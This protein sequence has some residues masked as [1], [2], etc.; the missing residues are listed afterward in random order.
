MDLRPDRAA[1]PGT[2][3]V[4]AVIRVRAVPWPHGPAEQ[5]AAG[6]AAAAEALAAAGSTERT[7]PRGPGGRPRF[8]PGF[9]GSISHTGRLAVAVV[10]PGAEAVGIDV[11]D[12]VVTA[13]TARF[14]L[15]ERERRT[16]LA[17]AGPYPPRELF[18]AKEAAFKALSGTGDTPDGLPFW[19]IGLN[20]S[21]GRLTARYGGR[22]V[23]VWTRSRTDHSL[24]LAI[25]RR[26][27]HLALIGDGKP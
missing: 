3:A 19:R 2:A 21:G 8:P 13:R 23:P 12:A 16:L 9:P 4:R 18:A 26:P 25:R 7:V 17:P 11:E 6:R 10:V 27:A 5:S 24:A 22:S 20:R 1:A 14:V 15:G